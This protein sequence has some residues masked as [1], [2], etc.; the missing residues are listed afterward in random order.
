LERESTRQ[1]KEQYLTTNELSQRIKMSPGSIRNLVWNNEL[2]LNVHYVKPTARKILFVWSAVEKWLW[3]GNQTGIA[4]R[5]N[6]LIN[7]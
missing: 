6:G 4:G 2:K 3:G 7:I 1:A 5:G